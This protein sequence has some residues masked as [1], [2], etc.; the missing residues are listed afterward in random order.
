MERSVRGAPGLARARTSSAKSEIAPAAAPAVRRAGLASAS[1]SAPVVSSARWRT[2]QS[3]Q[4]VIP[5]PHSLKEFR[6]SYRG[7]PRLRLR[8]AFEACSRCPSPGTRPSSRPMDVPALR[9]G[10][11]NRQVRH[12]ASD[13]IAAGRPRRRRSGAHGADRDSEPGVGLGDGVH[14]RPKGLL[15]ADRFQVAVPRREVRVP[16][17]CSPRVRL[18]AAP[19]GGGA[20]ERG[21]EAG[22]ILLAATPHP[23]SRPL[24]P[25]RKRDGRRLGQTRPAA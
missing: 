16:F 9:L 22:G 14:L 11:V 15:A 1:R 17:A 2:N 10:D 18:P 6:A 7:A 8:A 25:G 5:G 24:E 3:S 4:A 13:A 12:R 20:A 19:G 21:H 23:T